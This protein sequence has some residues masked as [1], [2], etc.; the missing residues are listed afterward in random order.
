VKQVDQDFTLQ[1][2]HEEAAALIRGKPAI[3]RSVFDQLL[4][5][6]RAR[7]FTVTG[8]EGANTLQ[9]IR[10]A[11]AGIATGQTWDDAKKQIVEDLDP[12]LGDGAQVRAEM[13]LRTHG[14]QAFQGA[15]WRSAQ[16]DPDTTHLQYLTMEDDRVR[17][18][19]AALDGVVLPKDD[20]FWAKHFPPWEWG[21]R[22]LTRSM[23][24]DQVD[25]ERA[26]DAD[27]NPEDHNVIEGA[28][29][30]QLEHGTLMREGRRFDVTAP[31]DGP[32]GAVAF[33]W[34]P[35]NL[36][37]PITQL[38]SHYDPGIWLQFEAWAKN[39]EIEPGRTI[40]Q[41]LNEKPVKSTRK[42]RTAAKTEAPAPA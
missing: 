41:W 19:H 1:A 11:I 17:D 20:P 39:Q 42:R 30:D 8:I 23:N 24:S 36:R 35:D 33:Q 38:Q 6:L 28:V 4:P 3:T 29:R 16:K 21:C 12:Y 34:H 18:S 5:E 15:F 9:R 31:S 2:P 26:A 40:W 13:L 27:K 10:D 25:E 37:L 14:F 32:D 7:A 22:C